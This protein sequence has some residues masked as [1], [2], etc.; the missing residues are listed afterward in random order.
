MRF[1]I[2]YTLSLFPLSPLS[3]FPPSPFQ[4]QQAKPPHTSQARTYALSRGIIIADTKLEFG[5]DPSNNEIVLID[6][7]LTPDSSRFWPA[8]TYLPGGPQESFDKQYLRDWLTE[9]KLRGV[10][11]VE[12][13]D[14]VVEKTGGKYREAYECLV[15]R[16]WGMEEGG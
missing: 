9:N 16:D 1:T 12:I 3:P 10:E 6:E 7:V 8:A 15:A 13:P 5:L 14:D 11:G 2:R 4:N